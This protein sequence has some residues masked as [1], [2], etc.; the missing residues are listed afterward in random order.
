M[1][2]LAVRFTGRRCAEVMKT[3]VFEYK[4]PYS[5]M[6]TGAFKRRGE[7]VTLVFEQTQVNGTK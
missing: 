3:A 1:R 6:F 2:K 7:P 5:V 4:T